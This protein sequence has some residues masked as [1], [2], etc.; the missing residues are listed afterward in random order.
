MSAPTSR[1]S[2]PLGG[3]VSRR[4]STKRPHQVRLRPLD[5]AARRSA[6]PRARAPARRSR[7]SRS[8]ARRPATPS[9]PGRS[10]AGEEGGVV[11]RVAD[12]RPLA[13]QRVAAVDRK[14]DRLA[15]SS[16]T[17]WPRG[18]RRTRSRRVR[19]ARELAPARLGVLPEAHALEAREQHR[20]L[21]ARGA[22]VLDRVAQ[23]DERPL[24][25]AGRAGG[26]AAGGARRRRSTT[27]ARRE[28][29][30]A[31]DRG[32]HRESGVAVARHL[33]HARD[34][35]L[36]VAAVAAREAL[37]VGE[38]V[39][40]LPHPQRALGDPGLARRPRGW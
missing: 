10:Q 5:E 19:R 11:G 31:I 21:G 15:P 26:R 7:R 16:G 29:A 28:L 40:R 2:S 37:R 32:L 14:L 33:A 24:R 8:G 23:P 13:P 1:S 36:A 35:V 17:R 25:R 27:R 9:W 3:G 22:L 18:S 34:V 39:A 38:A 12:E 30:R 20:P 4:R 6:R